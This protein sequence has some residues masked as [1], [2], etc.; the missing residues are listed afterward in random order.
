[1]VCFCTKCSGLTLLYVKFLLNHSIYVFF[2][3]CLKLSLPDLASMP[4]I[5]LLT[6]FNCN[7][8]LANPQRIGEKGVKEQ[9][10]K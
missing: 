2:Y 10:T 1:M 9:E 3:A 5:V 8:F 6:Y 4:I 7:Q